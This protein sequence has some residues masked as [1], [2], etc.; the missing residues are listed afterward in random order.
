MA[1]VLIVDTGE[2]GTWAVYQQDDS[3]RE[4]GTLVQTTHADHGPGLS[5][6]VPPGVRVGRAPSGKPSNLAF[7]RSNSSCNNTAEL[8]KLG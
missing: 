1:R 4:P 8:C 5:P 6:D 2:R 7:A 3:P